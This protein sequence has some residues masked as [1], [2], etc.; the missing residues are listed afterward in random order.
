MPKW[1]LWEGFSLALTAAKAAV[2]YLGSEA[3]LE[4]VYL[5]VGL[6]FLLLAL[7]AWTL[8]GRREAGGPP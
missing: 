8:L 7:A 3:G 2:G 5:G 4:V 1:G 6:G